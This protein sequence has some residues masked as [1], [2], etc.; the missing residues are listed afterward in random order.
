MKKLAWRKCRKIFFEAIFSRSRKLFSK[1][2]N[3][4][5]F[6]VPPDIIGLASL[7]LSLSQSLSRIRMC[8]LHWGY[9]FYTGVTLFALVLHFLHWCYTRTA[10][11]SANQNRVIFSWILLTIK[12]YTPSLHYSFTERRRTICLFDAVQSILTPIKIVKWQ[13]ERSERIERVH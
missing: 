11:L 8:N 10:L 6:L 12:K 1:V 13:Y 3:K 7:L 5:F 9:T 4:I 2:P